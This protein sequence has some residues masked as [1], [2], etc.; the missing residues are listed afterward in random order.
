MLGGCIQ[1]LGVQKCMLFEDYFP[2]M[3]T[4]GSIPQG[5]VGGRAPVW[6]AR[7]ARA[8]GVQQIEKCP[9]QNITE[10]GLLIDN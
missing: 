2:A 9:L 3:G 6:M 7:A 10:I 5:T 4:G 1:F 8:C